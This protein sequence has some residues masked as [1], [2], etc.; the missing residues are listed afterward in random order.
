M[1]SE[2]LP[3][4]LGTDWNAYGVAA[5]FH[6]AYGIKSVALGM[7]RQRYTDNLDFLDVHTFENFD[8]QRV[9]VSELINFAKTQDKPLLLISCSDYYTGLIT[10]SKS[11]LNSYYLMNY[12]DLDMRNKLENKVDFYNIC[13][14]YDLPYPK[15]FVVTPKNKDDFKLPF[16]Y[17]VICKPNDSFKWLK[18]KFEGY[19]KAYKIDSEGELK[20]VLQLAYTYGYDDA[21]IIQDFIPGGA[22]AMF[23]V[24]AYV[25]TK[26]RVTMTHAAQTALDECLPND[27]GNY[28]ALIS[29]D[30]PMLVQ[31]VKNFLEKIDYRGFANFD[32]KYDTRDG[33]YKVFEINLRQGRSSMYMTY[34]GNNFVT[35][36]AEDLIDHRE[37]PYCNHTEEHLW[38][39]TARSVLKHYTPDSLKPK[40]NALLA[41]GKASFGLDYGSKDNFKRR[42]L[43]LRRK[44]STIKYYPKYMESI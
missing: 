3:V 42:S 30:Y 22:D 2:F 40:V 7:K 43:S 27:I 38:Y 17:P 4:I 9:F 10:E 24:N 16:D 13:E 1:Y 26:G 21:M 12:I 35:Y 32:F 33:I 29:G 44:L 14:E 5:S 39:M 20:R 31:D 36:L 25:D 19:K 34:A 18:S 37:L 23:V 6:M 11:E 8:H 41:E 15:T 28:N